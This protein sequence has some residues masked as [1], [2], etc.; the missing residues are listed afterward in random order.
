MNK[1]IEYIQKLK[2]AYIKCGFEKEWSHLMDI[3]N[4]ITIENKKELISEFP[5]IPESLI[6][7][8]EKIDGT[9]YRKYGNEEVTYYFFGSD[10]DKG[11]YPYYLFSAKDILENKD[12]ASNF[13]DLFYYFLEEPDEIYG[14]FVDE[15]IQ[16]N[17]DKLK[18]LNFSDCMNNGGTSSLFID[19]TPSPK[20]IKGQI[21]R[22]LHDPDELKVIANSFDEFL[23]M[24]MNNEFKFIHEDDF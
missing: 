4:G 11:E 5:E 22:Y 20:G 14:P 12:S 17:A 2:K 19:F 6:N 13:G 8:L 16:M 9:Y 1:G 21:I 10:V 24:L 7:I 3:A 15:K 18:W 23:D